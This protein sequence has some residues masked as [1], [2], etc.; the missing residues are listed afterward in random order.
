M[1]L[2]KNLP[3]A[4]KTRALLYMLHRCSLDP[5]FAE[6]GLREVHDGLVYPLFFGI[7]NP[8]DMFSLPPGEERLMVFNAMETNM[9]SSMYKAAKRVLKWRR[10]SWRQARYERGMEARIRANM[11]WPGPKDFMANPQEAKRKQDQAILELRHAMYGVRAR[12]GARRAL[13]DAATS[14]EVGSWYDFLA[15]VTRSASEDNGVANERVGVPR[16]RG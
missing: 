4:A 15:Q 11:D 9:S 2:D 1:P 5:R 3:V 13:L 14:T 7:T 8:I 12:R 10:R 16:M 6:S